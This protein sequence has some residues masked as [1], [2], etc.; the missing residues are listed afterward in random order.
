MSN[1]ELVGAPLIEGLALSLGLIG[2]T[3]SLGD[4]LSDAAQRG[5]KMCAVLG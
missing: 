5:T 4:G 3:E 2:L 1:V